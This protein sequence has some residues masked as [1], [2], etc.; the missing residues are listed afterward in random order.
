M[1]YINQEVSVMNAKIEN[2]SEIEKGLSVKEA[3]NA[4]LLSLFSRLVLG[5]RFSN[6]ETMGELFRAE[7]EQLLALTLWN[8]VLVC[9]EKLL[10]CLSNV[11]G[12]PPE[13]IV[14][15]FY[16]VVEK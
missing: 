3:T 14:R 2:L 12:M 6:Y 4:Q 9:I 8:R 16:S 7:K 13:Q 11:F 1:I 10:K 15:L 5:K